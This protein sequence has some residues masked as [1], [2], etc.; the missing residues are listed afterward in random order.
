MTDRAARSALVVRP[1]WERFARTTS[2][3]VGAAI[4]PPFVALYWLTVP[5]GT[6]LTVFVIH[7]VALLALAAAAIRLRYVVI[8]VDSRGIRE[9]GY[10]GR[11]LVTPPE[12][13]DSIL[14]LTVLS[15]SSA[16]SHLQL[17]VLDRSG[18]T[19]LRMPG[20][21]W[22]DEAIRGVELAVDVPVQRIAEPLT[23]R[24][25]RMLHG[26]QLHWHERHPAVTHTGVALLAAA[27]AAPV[28]VVIESLL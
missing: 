3:A 5:S 2:I 16:N 1:F 27:V 11:L 24:E 17:F 18:R 21:F 4:L 23:R 19:R 25:L 14:I 7:K 26:A 13:V 28:F 12:E 10:F 20:Q 6:W 22:S 15:P 9:R 8:K